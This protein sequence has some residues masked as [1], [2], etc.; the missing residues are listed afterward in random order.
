MTMY[1]VGFVDNSFQLVSDYQ[2]LLKQQSIILLCPEAGKSK[3]E[4]VQWVLDHNIRFLMVDYRLP[5]DFNFYGTDLVAYINCVLPDLPCMIMTAF[6]EDSIHE[7]LVIKNMIEDRDVLANGDLKEFTDKLKQAVD[8]FNNRLML[9]KQEY[10]E[11][12]KLKN[13]KDINAQQEE[14]FISLY[15]LLQAYGEIDEI[16]VAFLRAEFEEKVDSLIKKL[17]SLIN[18]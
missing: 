14:R 10:L 1:V 3:E 16:P 9:R 18:K 12:L 8:V 15:K 7:N 6:Q 4:I 13:S 5:P 11:L 17:N 2:K